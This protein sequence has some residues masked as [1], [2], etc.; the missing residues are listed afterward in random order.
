MSP[1]QHP[2]TT[3]LIHEAYVSDQM[4]R[5]GTRPRREHDRPGP[6]PGDGIRTAIGRTLI[7]IG[8]RIEPARARRPVAVRASR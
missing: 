7:A 3:R 2:G 5:N 4:D 1:I 6:A 8:T